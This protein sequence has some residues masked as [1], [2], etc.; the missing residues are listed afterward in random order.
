MDLLNAKCGDDTVDSLAYR[1]APA[2]Q[3]SQEEAKTS[4]TAK[5]KASTTPAVS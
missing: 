3:R 5:T 2:A 4:A 1:N